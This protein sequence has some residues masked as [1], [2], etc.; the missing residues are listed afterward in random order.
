MPL[1]T[2]FIDS[3]IF[4]NFLLKEKDLYEGSKKILENLESGRV[5][6]I[7]TLLNLMEIL[8][9]LRKYSQR[10]DAF[11]IKDVEELGEMNNLQIVIPSEVHIA[12]AYNIQK[13]L[14]LLP[15][16]SILLAVACD[17]AEVFITRDEELIKKAKALLPTVK[18]E[19]LIIKS[20]PPALPGDS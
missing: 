17:F 18:P 5:Q 19:D 2:I 20:K 13:Q 1:K 4:L 8:A 10:D 16:D 12:E 3:N 15:A 9:V 11:I 14:K 7:T 6:G